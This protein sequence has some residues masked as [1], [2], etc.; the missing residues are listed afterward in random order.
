M[1][2]HFWQP[3]GVPGSHQ[4]L[5][6]GPGIEKFQGSVPDILTQACTL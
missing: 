6:D 2:K 4:V 5:F 1:S 3:A